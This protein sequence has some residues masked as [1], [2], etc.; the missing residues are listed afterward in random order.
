MGAHCI[1]GVD[2]MRD[3]DIS[4]DFFE[5]SLM[6]NLDANTRKSESSSVFVDLEKICLS[7]GEKKKFKEFFD[8][9]REIFLDEPQHTHIAW[10]EVDIGSS[11]PVATNSSSGEAKFNRSLH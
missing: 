8:E 6:V 5:K 2:Y 9:F 11:S 1:V 4:F 7:E 3:R 10:H